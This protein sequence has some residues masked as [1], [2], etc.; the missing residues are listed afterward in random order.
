LTNQRESTNLPIG[1]SAD[2]EKE[3]KTIGQSANLP[4]KNNLSISQL[5]NLTVSY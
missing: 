3:K 1:L 2:Q 4:I 5:D